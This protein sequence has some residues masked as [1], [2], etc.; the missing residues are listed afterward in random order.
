MP[1][2]L[3]RSSRTALV[4]VAAF[5]AALVCGAAAAKQA[6]P[7]RS[8]DLYVKRD[9]WADTLAETR[10]RHQ[11]CR[12]EAMK[13]TGRTD[14]KPFSSGIVRGDAPGKRISVDV[15]GLARV[16][17]VTEMKRSPGN[18]TIWGGAVLVAK[19]GSRTPLADR[20]PLSVRVGWGQLLRHK[21]WQGHPFRIGTKTF[22]HGLW[23]HTDSEVVFDL[24][25]RYERLEAW[26]GMD[27][28]RAGGEAVFKV[29]AGPP[30]LAPLLW[31][32]AA[33]DFPEQ[34]AW[35]A[36]DAGKD[37]EAEWFDYRDDPAW[38]RR[39]V[40]RAVVGAG[41]AAAPFRKQL[42]D[43]VKGKTPPGDARWLTLYARARRAAACVEAAGAVAAAPVREHLLG[44]VVDL[45]EAETPPHE[46]AW[47]DLAARAR[48]LAKA[49]AP[50][51]G[52]DVAA[53]GPSVEALA[54][55]FPDRFKDAADLRKEI[56]TRADAWDALCRRLI[57]GD[58]KAP[59]EIGPFRDQVR[60]LWRTVR[61]GYGSVAALQADPPDPLI[62]EEWQRRDEALWRDLT[63]RDQIMQRAGETYR[64]EALILPDDRDPADVVL[65]R[66]AA[67]L[68]DLR[69]MPDAPDL[70]PLARRLERLRA[71]A[72]DVKVMFRPARFALFV[73]A[74]R[75]RRQV[76][77]A[78]PLLGFDRI[79]FVKHDRAI[80]NHMCD[81]YY[82]IAA[83]PGGGLYVLEDA[84][85]P[86]P[87]VR[88]VLEG[89]VVQNGRLK[90]RPLATGLPETPPNLR[91]DG[92]GGLHG[93]TD[94][95]T[96]GSFLSPDLSY[97]G[98]TVLFAYCECSGDP[99]H[100]FHVDP[101]RGH[102]AEG[103]CWHVFRVNL[104]GSGLV[105]LT[106]GTWND[107]DPC[108]LPNGRVAFISER[109]GGYLRC[110]RVCPTYTLY[111]MAPD[112]SHMRC[113]SVHET[114]EW[115]PSVTHDGRIIYTR[116][117]YVDRHGCTAHMPWITTLDGRDSR[118]VHGNFA[119]RRSRPDMEVDIRAVPGSPK[120]I[121]TAA[122]HHGQ[123]YGTLVLVD[124]DMEDNDGMAPVR[125][126]TPEVTFP[127]SQGG[128]Q[129]YG[130]A[131]PLS[132]DYYLCVYDPSMRPG[133]GRQGRGYV[134][135]KYG[136]YLADAFGNK[137]LVYRDP[138]IAC[139]SPIPVRPRSRPKVM[140]DTSARPQIT[141]AA[142]N[143]SD[144]GTPAPANLDAT[145][146]VIDVYDGQKTWPDGTRVTALRVFQVLPMSMPSGG[147]QHP[148]ETG[149]RLP[150][151]GDSVVP[152]RHLI[153]TVPV[154]QDG[155]AH[156]RVPAGREV[157]FQAVGEDGL[158]VQSMRSAT[159]VHPG[160][161]LVCQ[162]CHEH[163]HRAPPVPKRVPL[164]LRREPSKP[165]PGPEG[166]NPFSYPR[167]VQPV[168]EKHCLACH[169]KNPKKAPNLARDPV[170]RNWYAS[171]HS[172]ARRYGF[173]NYGD[174]YRTTPGAFGARASRLYAMLRDGHN[175]LRLPAE[176]LARIALW[177]DCCSMF[178]GVYEE[179]PGQ[180]QLDGQVAR[181]TLE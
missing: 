111:D 100:R 117:D 114:N 82:G 177:L 63:M 152:C 61:L 64:R 55:V 178:Y 149:L 12:A 77:F 31:R 108:W 135:G 171:Y 81:Q 160:E 51:E 15:S 66:T 26:I 74:C 110:G 126:I 93:D 164:A 28:D 98:K 136:I 131:W 156:F 120:F 73:E 62:E 166:S 127:E 13:E 35:L 99:K 42:E 123:A 95:P 94:A 121:A 10:A 69:S 90:G 41:A 103:R 44:R 11:R 89:A 150:S 27:A 43:L 40:G 139:L 105:Q 30:D 72:K 86:R 23:V 47:R 148:F 144:D 159:Y 107:F 56:E 153:G 83:R 91:Y 29:Q 133:V 176:D 80:Y 181:P 18:L 34:A 2:G 78:N 128:A 57:E 140:P 163:K 154:E 36:E 45:A 8:A 138:K 167:L 7:P 122:P 54:A 151:A 112:G 118:H 58:A 109:R 97:D 70:A 173:Y 116:W 1:H 21:N 48:R 155:S 137:V 147:G 143:L 162:G 106:D 32:K 19:D 46:K 101:T 6:P 59:A 38:E 39:L 52:M 142:P 65:R 79:L 87:H 76:A 130:T 75:L 168:L 170:S 146:A 124:P 179:G 104:D 88:N 141:Q 158:A 157:F 20:E 129:V 16:R 60:D 125:R 145:L 71:A 113:L 175:D 22:E 9:T 53:L 33:K 68:D 92:N 49:V 24:G 96:V 84:F 85:G 3:Q 134:P 67:L 37:R 165:K 132:E 174:G 17:L 161:R 180:A 50:M 115:H 119:P 25:G 5:A 14:F 169:E 102:W 172:L 4:L